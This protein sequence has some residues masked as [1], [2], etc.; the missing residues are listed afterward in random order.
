MPTELESITASAPR[1]TYKSFGLASEL[2]VKRRS[3]D[4]ST[5]GAE[6]TCSSVNA[7]GSELTEVVEEGSGVEGRVILKSFTWAL[8][9]A[10]KYNAA[11]LSLVEEGA[12]TR[13]SADLSQFCVNV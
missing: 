3:P 4:G 12:K 11:L 6:T 1:N 9:A 2:C 13:L 10:V 5:C 8:S 7:I